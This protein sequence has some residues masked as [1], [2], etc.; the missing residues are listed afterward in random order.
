MNFRTFTLLPFIILVLLASCQTSKEPPRFQVVEA[1]IQNIHHAL[2]ENRLTVEELVEIYLQRIEKYDKSTLLNSITA[3][4][5]KARERAKE[6]DEE[7]RQTGKLRPLHGICLVI[8]DNIE[9]KDMPTTAGSEALKNFIPPDDAFIVKKLR[10]AGAIILAKSN[11]AEWAFSPYITQSG[12]AGITRNPYDLNRVPAG[13]SGGTAAA[14]AANLVTIG[15]GTDTGNSVRGP[16]SHCCLVGLRPTLGLVSRDGIIPLYLR[17][18]T[19]GPMGRTVEDVAHILDIIA[20]YDPADPLTKMSEGK[21]PLSYLKFLDKNGLQGARV[22]VFRL[23]TDL[24]TADPQVVTLFEQAIEDLKRNGAVIVDP[25]VIPKFGEL[26]KN[27]W[28]DTFRHDLNQYL[29]SLG[30]KAPVK[31]LLEVYNKG[32]FS[33]YIRDRLVRALDQAPDK[34]LCQDIYHEPRNIAFRQAV[35]EAMAKQGVDFIIYPTWSNP[36]RKLGDLRSPAGDNSQLLSPHTGFPAITVPMGFISKNLPAGLQIV[37][38]LFSEPQLLKVAYA[39][40]QATLYRRPPHKF[41]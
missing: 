2:Q 9:T 10:E 34:V 41:D 35:L 6:L 37:G 20:G 18:D 19:A 27:L 16:S 28:C 13:S 30:E 39:Y 21:I 29:L 5:P 12:T 8:K 7:F 32:L 3:I 17:N 1:K 22:G 11:M 23:Y 31:N 15:L 24:P 33:L 4:N 14:V 26:T 38:K 40:E 25:F 36:P